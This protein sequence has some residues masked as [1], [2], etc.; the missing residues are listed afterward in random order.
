MIT[1][2]SGLLTW[3]AALAVAA[4]AL[5]GRLAVAELAGRRCPHRDCWTTGELA[6][7][8]DEASLEQLLGATEAPREGRFR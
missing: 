1:G 8:D 6:A 4:V 3:T 2:F 7:L 5:A